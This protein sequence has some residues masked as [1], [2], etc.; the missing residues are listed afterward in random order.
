MAETLR[1]WECV[2]CDGRLLEHTRHAAQ[3]EGWITGLGPKKRA[4][5]KEC[6]VFVGKAGIDVALAALEKAWHSK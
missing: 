4:V 1:D 3:H 5:C 6:F 2:L